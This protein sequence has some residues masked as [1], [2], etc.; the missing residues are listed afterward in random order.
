MGLVKH[1]WMEAVERGWNDIEDKYVCET[2]VDDEFLK[3]QILSQL[4]ATQCDYCQ[5]ESGEPIAA[6]VEVVQEP[7]GETVSFYFADPAEA[8]VPRNDGEWL[9]EPIDT[10]EVLL[11]LGL[12]CQDDLFSDIVN[13]FTN[14]EW[15]RA[16]QGSWS[17][18]RGDEILDY[19]WSSFCEWIKHVTRFFFAEAPSDIDEFDRERI[20]YRD[21]LPEL[22]R[23]ANDRGL[24]SQVPKGTTLYRARVRK[25]DDRWTLNA[26]TMGAPPLSTTTA[27][28][29]NPAGISY[30]YL[31]FDEE[32]A[33]AEVLGAAASEVAVAQF[34]TERELIILD[35]STLPAKPSIFDLSRRDER[36]SLIFLE[37]FVN[38]ISRSIA[39]DGLEHVSYVPSQVVCEYF[40]LVFRDADNKPLD[41]VKFRSSVISGGKNLVLF[42][43]QR[44]FAPAFDQVIYE[45]GSIGQFAGT[46]QINR[47]GPGT[48]RAIHI[49]GRS[50]AS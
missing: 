11:Q 37:S 4:V 40:A 9:V 24:I 34:S 18:L 44:G 33:V 7:I 26:E 32:T 25:S 19:S 8:G 5:A 41:G 35:L 6:P 39:K 28:R 46:V 36:E 16:V 42:P 47:E 17:S 13:A 1:E 21:V 20:E 45:R 49:T 43:T 22:G 38:T 10:Q 3:E 50:N 14:D 12:H 27:G 48:S 30:L 31:A 23:L 29:M 15:V 2:C